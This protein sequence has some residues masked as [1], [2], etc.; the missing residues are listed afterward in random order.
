MRVGGQHHTPAALPP[1]ETRYPL[2]RRLG[3]PKDRSEGVRKISP[4]PRFDLRTVQPKASRSVF[5]S[6]RY[7]TSTPPYVPVARFR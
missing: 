7:Y 3:V 4:S 2:Y 6:A 5:S 1:E